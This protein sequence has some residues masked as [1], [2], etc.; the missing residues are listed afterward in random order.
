MVRKLYKFDQITLEPQTRSLK[1]GLENIDL[2]YLPAT[3]LEI[4]LKA[5]PDPVNK[6]DLKRLAWDLPYVDDTN[7]RSAIAELRSA[8]GDHGKKRGTKTEFAIIGTRK[9]LGYYIIPA[10]SVVEDEPASD[11]HAVNT[12][13]EPPSDDEAVQPN[14]V[15]VQTPIPAA[16]KRLKL[17]AGLAI[18][19]VCLLLVALYLKGFSS[20]G[21]SLTKSVAVLNFQ[22]MG[23]ESDLAFEEGMTEAI[24]VRLKR[25]KQVRVLPLVAVR[26]YRGG[27]K[28]PQVVGRELKVDAVLEGHIEKTVDKTRVT[29]HL[30]DS[31]SGSDLW[32]EVFDEPTS[33][34]FEI[35]DN[36][37]T[38]VAQKIKPSLTGQEKILLSKHDTEN[39]DARR[40]YDL[41]RAAW[42][43]RTTA[44][45][46]QSIKYFEQ[47]ITADPNYARAYVGL[48]DSY[49][50]R[51]S[52][53]FAVN[54]PRAGMPKA[55][56]AIDKALAIDSEL[57]EAHATAGFIAFV[58]DWDLTAAQQHFQRAIELDPSYHT[59]HQWYAHYLIASG[60][61]DEALDEIRRAQGIVQNVPIISATEIWILYYARRYDEAIE[62]GRSQVSD[63]LQ[64]FGPAHVFL[65][66]AYEEKKMYKEAISE[67]Q[68]SIKPDDLQAVPL[69]CLGHAYAVSGQRDKAQAI[70]QELKNPDTE[71]YPFVS[72]FLIAVIYIGLGD[73]E[74]AMFWLEKAEAEKS[75]WLVE[76]NVDPRFDPL[77]AEP[78]FQALLNRVK[79]PKSPQSSEAKTTH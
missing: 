54:A 53:G 58:Y 17:V 46:T 67:F 78:R 14:E 12:P 77:H 23:G 33:H 61:P 51:S 45:L 48:A 21:A 55:R 75:G 10:V 74:N 35:E 7:L 32:S 9:K 64:N 72:A 6:E 43:T 20:R 40:F 49:A 34:R 60:K 76:L 29:V 28:V 16:R 52:F 57:A 2:A 5:A 66:F 11:V 41:G 13:P 44:G 36:I 56:Q 38:R 39:E 4:L 25:I 1:R 37:A 42:S 22:T 8:L 31:Q 30:V 3:I 73:K 15:S 69:A 19:S 62:I 79:Q 47:A 65:G 71:K 26:P 68:K 70:L 63:K 27:T 24:I 50:Q 59:S 18:A